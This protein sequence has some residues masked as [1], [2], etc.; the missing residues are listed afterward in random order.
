MLYSFVASQRTF[1]AISYSLSTERLSVFNN[2]WLKKLQIVTAWLTTVFLLAVL[3]CCCSKRFLNPTRLIRCLRS[4]RIC[5]LMIVYAAAIVTDYTPGWLA[6]SFPLQMQ[7]LS[8]FLNQSNSKTR[9]LALHMRSYWRVNNKELFS[10]AV[11]SCGYGWIQGRVVANN[12]L[13]RC[14]ITMNH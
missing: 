1:P 4:N 13:I 12:W 2:I 11:C 3:K 14:L 6:E 8:V 9:P 5:S 10:K 7:T